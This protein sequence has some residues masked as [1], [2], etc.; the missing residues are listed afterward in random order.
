MMNEDDLINRIRVD[1]SKMLETERL[2]KNLGQTVDF[3][4]TFFKE[5]RVD[6]SV[7]IT[8]I[9]FS[10][11]ALSEAIDFNKSKNGSIIR[12]RNL[13]DIIFN[14]YYPRPRNTTFYHFTSLNSFLSIIEKSELWLFYLKKRFSQGEFREFYADH[15]LTG[16]D[17]KKHNSEEKDYFH[18]I[19]NETFYISFARSNTINTEEQDD[20]W[21]SFGDEHKG[22]RIEF[23]I[24]TEHEDF[25]NIYYRDNNLD[26]ETLLL[27]KFEHV[28]QKKFNR[29][30]I[31]SGV[32][33]IGAFYLH[34]DFDTEHETR[35]VIKKYTDTYPFKFKIESTSEGFDFIR[36]PFDSD[37]GKFSIKSVKAGKLLKKNGLL[38]A[39]QNHSISEN[40]KI[41]E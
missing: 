4:N 28:I 40:F 39:L 18:S 41:I 7:D 29:I 35:F 16:Y 22:V 8:D 38:R 3:I 23:E 26:L 27:N 36:L 11:Q 13:S 19:V 10:D 15:G 25:R 24:D 20:L 12:K 32:S 37:Y 17:K 1:T 6:G 31:I 2:N 21:V 30:P 34:G 9:K 5:N 33:K 14:S